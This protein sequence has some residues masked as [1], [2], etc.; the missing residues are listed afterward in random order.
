MKTWWSPLFTFTWMKHL[1]YA[2]VFVLAT[3]LNHATSAFYTYA[4]LD[5][6]NMD[7]FLLLIN[8]P[9]MGSYMCFHSCQ[10]MT[11]HCEITT[12]IQ[13]WKADIIGVPQMK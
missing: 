5:F 9:T 3:N 4:S 12:D 1:Y 7:F 10:H 8:W 13:K 11:R 2:F 6:I